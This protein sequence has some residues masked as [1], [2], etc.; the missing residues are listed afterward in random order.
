[1]IT[2]LQLINIVIVII[3]YYYNG[4]GERLLR[5]TNCF[6]N[7]NVSHFLFKGLISSKMCIRL[8]YKTEKFRKFYNT[9]LIL[10]YNHS[11]VSNIRT[12]DKAVLIKTKQEHENYVWCCTTYKHTQRSTEEN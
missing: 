2:Q 6:L 12:N 9:K 10:L 1:V 4:D 11:I 7:K 3:Y 8:K 5:G